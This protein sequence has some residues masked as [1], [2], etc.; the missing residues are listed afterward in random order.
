MTG[1]LKGRERMIKTGEEDD[2]KHCTNQGR[3]FVFHGAK[4]DDNQVNETDQDFLF[5]YLFVVGLMG[6][7]ACLPLFS[8]VE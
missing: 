5:G 6:L 4:V 8:F 7:E 3:R 1:K 2:E